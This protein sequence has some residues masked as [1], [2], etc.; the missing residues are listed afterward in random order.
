[1]TEVTGG[2]RYYGCEMGEEICGK[3]VQT[4]NK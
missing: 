4:A 3:I 2:R 1:M